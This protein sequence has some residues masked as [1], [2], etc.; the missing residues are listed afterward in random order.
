MITLC[1]FLKKLDKFAVFWLK[2]LTENMKT[3]K[4]ENSKQKIITV[5]GLDVYPLYSLCLFSNHTI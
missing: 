1:S 3:Y 5:G 4:E 2:K